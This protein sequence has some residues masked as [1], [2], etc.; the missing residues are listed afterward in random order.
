MVD[1]ANEFLGNSNVTQADMNPQIKIVTIGAGGAGCNTVNRLIKVGVKGTEL[2]AINTDVNHFKIIDDRI[3]KILIG[4]SITRGLGAGGSPDV[5]AKAAEVD[6]NAL[7]EILSGAQLVFLCAGMGGGTGTGSLPVLAQIAKEQGAIV[8]SMVTYPFDLERVRKV[9]AEEGI[10]RLRKF[11]DSVIILDNNRLVKLHPNLPMNEAFAVADDVLAKAIGGLVWTITQPS[12][13]NIDFADV[14]SIMG[15]GDVGFI[16]YGLGKGNDKVGSAAE[17]VLKNKLLDVDYENAK[18]ALIHISGASDLTLGDAIK[19][20]E[21]ITER[22]DPK[23]NVKWGA[24]L[25]PGYEGQLEIVAIVTGV[26]GA[27]IVGHMVE[28]DK[29]RSY[30]DIEMI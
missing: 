25:I 22:M 28:K 9:K 10:Q 14:R 4:K 17:A 27:S 18:G 24:R 1:F 20:G 2:V 19:A 11:S 23:A 7:E 12:L 15:S 16:A 13:I 6:R 29:S 5:G 30:S 21:L 3:K 26:S 8:V